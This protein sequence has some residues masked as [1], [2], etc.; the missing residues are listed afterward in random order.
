LPG[1][2]AEIGESRKDAAI[3][4][5]KEETDL[6]TCARRFLFEYESMTNSH[7]VFLIKSNGVAR[8]RNEIKYVDFLMDQSLKCQIRLG[9]SLRTTQTKKIVLRNPLFPS[10][11]TSRA[12]AFAKHQSIQHVYRS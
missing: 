11:V 4:E 12:S 3:R 6:Q 8:P 9:K 10:I 7:K 5:L 2:G 1:G